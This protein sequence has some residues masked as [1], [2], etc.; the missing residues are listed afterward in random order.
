M[1]TIFNLQFARAIGA[2]L[3]VYAHIGVPGATF[4]H[5]GVDI[6]F[7]ISGY[8]MTMICVKSSRNFFGRR[9]AR[10]VPLYWLITGLVFLLSWYKPQ[11]M[12]S[13]TPSVFNLVRSL[14]FIPYVKENGLIHPMLDV[15]WT[16]NYE[17]YFYTAIALALLL[18]P[19]RVATLAASGGLIVVAALLQGLLHFLPQDSY[20]AVLATFYSSF[21]VLEFVL[22]VAVFYLVQQPIARKLGTIANL[23]LAAVCL[24]FLAYNQLRPPLGHAVPLLTQGIPA[25][26]FV[27][28]LLLLEQ[29]NFV[30]TKITILGDASYALYLTNQFVVEGFR[31]IASKALHLSFYSVPSIAM[32]IVLASAVAIMIYVVLEKP[33]H[34]RLRILVDGKPAPR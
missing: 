4:G 19:A 16:L 13:T 17:M 32:V 6:F 11:L 15:G 28:T 18:V 20:P 3:V 9:L 24:V 7:V 21:Y 14:F 1:K 31:K 2:L 22:G 34:D 8:I 23:L 33:L 29:R 12:N 10:I 25:M 30:F 26:L 27:A 5:F